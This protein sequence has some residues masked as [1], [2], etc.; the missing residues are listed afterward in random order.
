MVGGMGGGVSDRFLDDLSSRPP[1]RNLLEAYYAG[2]CERHAPL[3]FALAGFALRSIGSFT[4]SDRALVA[5][6]FWA[7]WDLGPAGRHD[8]EPTKRP[9]DLCI[10]SNGISP[11]DLAAP[12]VGARGGGVCLETACG[13]EIRG[14]RSVGRR[15]KTDLGPMGIVEVTTHRLGTH[16]MREALQEAHHMRRGS[17]A[18]IGNRMG[19]SGLRSIPKSASDEMLP[20]ERDF[21]HATTM[22]IG[23]VPRQYVRHSPSYS[24]VLRIL[25]CASMAS[26]IERP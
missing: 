15:A 18:M 13:K 25:S 3:A 10:R 2:V 4:A 19:S 22:L 24:V 8:L 21:G 1:P 7:T 23:R 14:D 26:T 11:G 16:V 17:P 6:H 20:S 12:L 9:G 5:R